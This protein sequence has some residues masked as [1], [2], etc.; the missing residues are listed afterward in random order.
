MHGKAERMI[1]ILSRLSRKPRA[2]ASLGSIERLRELF[3]EEP[4]LARAADER[5]SLLFCLPD[6]EE[7]A[8]E[9]AE[10]LLAHGADP[11]VTD[12]DGTTAA[13]QAEKQG[14]DAVAD[15]LNEFSSVRS[16]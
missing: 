8:L 3:A 13:E 6:D 12:K 9:V 5:G 4:T 14:L 2:L 10:L 1:A 15:L 7:R 11:R 16:K